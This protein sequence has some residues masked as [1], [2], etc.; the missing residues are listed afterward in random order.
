MGRGD[1]HTLIGRTDPHWSVASLKQRFARQWLLLLGLLGLIGIILTV[2]IRQNHQSITKSEQNHLLTLAAVAANTLSRQLE[3]TDGLLEA[4]RQETLQA[5][6]RQLSH[7][8][9]TQLANTA[10]GIHLL[11]RLD[12]SGNILA[13]NQ[14]DLLSQNFS[15]R[16]YFSAAKEQTGKTG[17]ISP[18]FESALGN[19]SF[20]LSRALHDE[21][22]QFKGVLVAS[23]NVP[24]MAQ[25]L[26]TSRYSEDMH[27]M[28]I[29]GNGTLI[30]SFPDSGTTLPQHL[31][32]AQR[33]NQL[34]DGL[35][36]EAEAPDG[37][38]I[39]IALRTVL[40][41]GLKLDQPLVIAVSRNTEAIFA[42]WRVS[43]AYLAALY[44]LLSLL[45]TLGLFLYQRRGRE[46]WELAERQ[47]A[48]LETTTD[49]IY[50]LRPD[51]QLV[52]ANPGF[53]DMLGLAPNA[54]HRT[55]I[56]ELDAG[57]GSTHLLANLPTLISTNQAMLFET[58]HRHS[59][60]KLIDVEINCRHIEQDGTPLILAVSRNISQRKQ[61]ENRL[62]L[63]QRL[64]ESSGDM[65][66]MLDHQQ[67]HQIVNP[68]YA[69]LTGRQ[70]EAVLGHH[71]ATVLGA[72]SYRKI[73][74][75][76]EVALAGEALGFVFNY[77]V[78]GSDTRI[79]QA[80]LRPLFDQ[81][82]RAGITL[83]LH[84][85]SALELARQT[86]KRERDTAKLY[87]DTMQTIMVALDPYG[88]V[89]MINR[90]GSKLLDLKAEALIGSKW[91]DHCTNATDD[92][93]SAD[94]A[95][96]EIMAGHLNGLEQLE[97]MLLGRDGVQHR[98][99]W[100]HTYLKDKSGE[101]F[102]LLCS[103]EDITRQRAD[104][105]QIQILSQAIEQS[106]SSVVLTDTHGDIEYVNPAFCRISGYGAKELIGQNPKL[107]Q[108]GQTPQSTHRSLW[109]SLSQGQ[110]WQGEMINRRKDGS[111]YIEQEIITP[112]RNHSGKISH[113]LALKDDITE[114]K[115]LEGELAEQ[116]RHLEELVLQRT[117]ELR[118]A[119]RELELARDLAESATSAKSDFLANM[120]HE[121]RTP[122]NAIIGITH[123]LQREIQSASQLARL[124]TV[125]SA[126]DHL[127]AVINDI[128]DIS[129][130]E[131]GHLVLDTHDFV[132]ADVI[133]NIQA[134]ISDKLQQ[135]HLSFSTDLSTI[136]PILNG[137]RTRISQVLI[138][139]L[140]NAVK[141]TESGNISL[142]G[143]IESET[144]DGYELKFSVKDSGIGIA[145]EKQ[146]K[147]F[148]AFE[149]ADR[150]ST[151]RHGGTGLGLAI[152]KRLA[153][154][155]GGSVGCESILGQGST[156]WVRLK[157]GR[158]SDGSIPKVAHG[159]RAEA[160][161]IE[162]VLRKKY[163]GTSILVA[164]DE[165][166]NQEVFTELLGEI[167]G[168]NVQIADN[169]LTAVNMA[170]RTNF[171]L[172]L[173]DMQMPEL[174]GVAATKAIRAQPRHYT[175]PIIAV[176]ANVFDEDVKRCLAAG[177][178]DYL[179]K[180]VAPEK[181]FTA[182][183]QWLEQPSKNH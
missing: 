20:T 65:L 182:I 30:L 33:T 3:Q 102:G 150:S 160:L 68:A 27:T 105:E 17:V 61:A 152:N 6:R 161:P 57:P 135:K 14:P 56:T 175:T 40:P 154:L 155:M 49:G 81:E 23:L 91:F 107:L 126:A 172:I 80:T 70:P 46:H 79:L 112:V 115:R 149:Q 129:K 123:L 7:H 69:Q 86:A 34:T 101:I 158:A 67:R 31:L 39:L 72:E 114:R 78:H 15:H 43:S 157:L 113:Y 137:D 35:V 53:F 94:L 116:Q 96:K 174:D 95:F 111:I 143:H 41:A 170:S 168:L 166:I 50:L 92:A 122:L 48:I 11:M 153:T 138:N 85:I 19:Y 131:A 171:R 117:L 18:P 51:G 141:F 179:T 181:L 142:H 44:L 151:R 125:R 183:L 106:P 180:P 29:H 77:P 4:L 148:T 12:A 10:P 36:R 136:P 120:S 8:R 147:L 38:R 83:S 140:W 98:I 164:E 26:A 71:I 99:R 82:Q 165:A 104:E 146:A 93:P 54:L 177:M 163:A 60:G 159:E 89:L 25:L 130:I 42:D 167:A 84:D 47:S 21:H 176:S 118:T 9:I 74:P 1:L 169:G 108:S 156:F 16:Y 73:A 119:N 97:Y 64:V 76:L 37:S 144:K 62:R 121:I 145:P 139:Y 132:F 162:D 103:G 59:S 178:D 5:G 110:T 52:D 2:Q 109:Q 173:M 75:Y 100:N 63:Y 133:E 45:A 66:A 127:L 24:F 87:L 58:R 32:D 13:A 90:A 88:R 22:D 134:L 124:K 128:L 28:L 55:N